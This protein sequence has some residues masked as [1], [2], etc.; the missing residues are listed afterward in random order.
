MPD[1]KPAGVPCIHLDKQMRCR[2]FHQPDR[3]AVCRSLQPEETMCGS[4]RDDAMKYLTE[5]EKLTVP[6]T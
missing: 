3:P 1:G 5:L 2:I 4:C 6:G